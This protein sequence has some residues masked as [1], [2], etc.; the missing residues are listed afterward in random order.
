MDDQIKKENVELKRAN[1]KL[2]ETKGIKS[3]KKDKVERNL[4][5]TIKR[6]DDIMRANR[7]SSRGKEPA[8]LT[9]GERVALEREIRRYIA[10]S[11]G[12]R[13]NLPK[14]KQEVCRNL[15]KRIGRTK[16]EWDITIIV[17]GMRY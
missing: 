5:G 6:P 14:E 17:P 11:G 15:M 10:R 12:F 16:V 4:D 8:N 13:E 9:E 7:D 2:R 3:A 1:R